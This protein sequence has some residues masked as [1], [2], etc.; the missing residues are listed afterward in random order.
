[1]ILQNDLNLHVPPPCTYDLVRNL[2]LRLFFFLLGALKG[3]LAAVPPMWGTLCIHVT[4][5]LPLQYV[6]RI[7]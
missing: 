2:N 1:M 4:D 7:A 6:N 3:E 5:V